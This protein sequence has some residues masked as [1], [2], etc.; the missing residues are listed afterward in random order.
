M[1]LARQRSPRPAPLRGARPR[2]GGPR[3]RPAARLGGTARRVLAVAVATLT[4]SA[5]ALVAAPAATAA[6]GDIVWSD[7]FDGAAGSAHRSAPAVP[8]LGPCSAQVRAVAWGRPAGQ[9]STV[10]R[11]ARMSSP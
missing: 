6:P 9:D 4:V 2:P 7:E 1:D 3:R 5:G 11:V 10:S 8:L